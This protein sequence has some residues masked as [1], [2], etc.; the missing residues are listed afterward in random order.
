MSFTVHK[1]TEEDWE[2][3]MA[4][5]YRTFQKYVSAGYSKEGVD[6]FVNFISDPHLYRMFQVDEYFL[7]VVRDEDGMI[8][9][10]GTLRSG[11]H[12]SLLFV[13]E[14]WIR[15]GVGSA[16]MS[17]FEQYVLQQ[18]KDSITVN[19][20]PYG[21]PFYHKLGFADTGS[22]QVVGG[23]TITPMKKML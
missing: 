20:S 19:A 23:M 6:N 12:I 15:R 14:K 8:I 1:G 16:I 22:E 7:W 13:D 11:N 9:G 5:A 10:M 21:V 17:A 4:L 18:G 2:D 3:A